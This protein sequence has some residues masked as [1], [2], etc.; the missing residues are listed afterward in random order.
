MDSPDLPSIELPRTEGADLRAT[1][2]PPT[3]SDRPNAS[4]PAFPR[5]GSPEPGSPEPG[6]PE[7]GSAEPGLAEPG[8]SGSPVA[9][10]PVAANPQPVRTYLNFAVLVVCAFVFVRVVLVEPFGVPTGSMAPAIL[11]NH[12]NAPC[13]RCG[14]PVRVGLPSGGG[15]AADHFSHIACPNCGKRFSLV[16]E[17]DVTGDRLFVDKHV[18]SLRKPRRWEMAVFHCPD[19]DPRE[20]RRPYIKRVVGLPGE[21]ITI[22]DGDVYADGELLRKDAAA[23]EQTRIP[24]LDLS[25]YPDC[26]WGMRFLVEPREVD[27][28]LPAPAVQPR[29]SPASSSVV[30][31]GLLVLDASN[32]PQDRIQLVYRQWNF[33]E[34]REDVIRAWNSYDGVP[35][36]FGQLPPVH[37][38]SLSCEL[39][40]MAL[41]QAALFTCGLTDGLDTVT[42][43]VS[44]GNRA[45][46]LAVLSRP[47]GEP[48][49]TV[50]GVALDP[51]RTN[52]VVF[53]FVDRRVTLLVNGREL[54]PAVDLPAAD[55]RGEVRRPFTLGARGCKLLVRELKLFRDTYYTQDG[56]NGVGDRNGVPRPVRL[57]ADEYFLLGDNSGNSQDSRVWRKRDAAGHE[58][59]AAGVPE[60]WFIGKPFLVHQPLRPGRV[61]IGGRERTFQTLDWSRL[62]WLH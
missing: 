24:V 48:L 34:D 7:P 18:Y 6:S 13:P 22:R 45:E 56:R 37:D 29:L 32:N 27:P 12:R 55:G 46:G 57:G 19:P 21:S 62:R 4:A 16:G 60:A 39:E 31:G 49:A 47:T 38:F 15:N 53:S 51:E 14:Y 9:T 10:A 58:V 36:S 11:G 43:E 5:P 41:S 61:M 25:Y 35:R 26:G 8:P 28:R 52:Y 3:A 23:V 1:P 42:A 40:V 30:K 17:P 59:S 33:D 20:Y 50:R 44:V 2:R 54:F